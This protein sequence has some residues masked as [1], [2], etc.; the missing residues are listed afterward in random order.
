MEWYKTDSKTIAQYK[1]DRRL[2]Y[3][4]LKSI[5]WKIFWKMV[6]HDMKHQN[7]LDY[8]YKITGMNEYFEFILHI[9]YF[10]YFNY[11]KKMFETLLSC[12]SFWD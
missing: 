1:N 5:I 4:I 12:S 10:H 3:S 11:I 9:S 6:N 7:K 8:N 2:Y